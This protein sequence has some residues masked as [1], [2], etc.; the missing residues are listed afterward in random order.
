MN[1]ISMFYKWIFTFFTGHCIPLFK[2]KKIRL[3]LQKICI[4][5]KKDRGTGERERKKIIILL[6]LFYI[7]LTNKY[8]LL[9]CVLID[10][11]IK[12]KWCLK[13]FIPL[14]VWWLPCI[15]IKILVRLRTI[16]IFFFSLLLTC[17]L[18]TFISDIS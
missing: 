6:V 7:I 17:L 9:S 2:K 3:K 12:K 13:W 4:V 18:H 8:V 10:I 14:S 11:N 15:F 16:L 1:F 5:I